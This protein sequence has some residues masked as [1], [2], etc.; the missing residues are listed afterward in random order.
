MVDWE[1]SARLVGR[2]E[3]GHAI[4][5]VWFGLPPVIW[6]NIV[7]VMVWRSGGGH[8]GIDLLVCLVFG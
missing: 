3:K 6:L 8:L 5:S 1:K 7:S 2:G 4:R